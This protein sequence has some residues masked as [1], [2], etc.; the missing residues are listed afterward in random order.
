[1]TDRDNYSR[2]HIADLERKVAKLE[3]ALAA[4]ESWET[5][6]HNRLCRVET[7]LNM[8]APAPIEDGGERVR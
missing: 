8:L 6:L 1:V 4:S 7:V 5:K 2:L 3:K